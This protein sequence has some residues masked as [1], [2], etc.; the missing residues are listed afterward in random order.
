[1]H[2]FSLL[3]FIGCANGSLLYKL[4]QR[5]IVC[6]AH[7]GQYC[8]GWRLVFFFISHSHTYFQL[9]L[10]RHNAYYYYS[11]YEYAVR[12]S[13]YKIQRPHDLLSS[14]RVEQTIP[15]TSVSQ[16]FYCAD[17]LFDFLAIPSLMYF[18][19]RSHRI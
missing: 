16:P 15:H 12:F 3:F 8:I 1:L 6:T 9:Y 10:L 5:K 17:H 4:I 2:N 13:R 7:V 18:F 14:G 19:I 11:V